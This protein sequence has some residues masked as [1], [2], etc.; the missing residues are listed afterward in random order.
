MHTRCVEV[1]FEIETL[2]HLNQFIAIICATALADFARD[3]CLID[4]LTRVTQVY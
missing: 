2:S 1:R 4:H 3:V